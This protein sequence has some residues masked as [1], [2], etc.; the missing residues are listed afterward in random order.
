[1]SVLLLYHTTHY[2]F[3]TLSCLGPVFCERLHQWRQTS[4]KP[5]QINEKKNHQQQQQHRVVQLSKRS[6]S[7]CDT[8]TRREDLTRKGIVCSKGLT[9]G[10]CV[11]SHGAADTQTDVKWFQRWV[12]KRQNRARSAAIKEISPRIDVIWVLVSWHWGCF[13]S[14]SLKTL[15]FVV[16]DKPK[17]CRTGGTSPVISVSVLTIYTSTAVPWGY[18]SP[19]R[20]G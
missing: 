9:L 13:F 16:K 14:F 17:S 10:C 2:A 1:M 20:V 7:F 3:S 18:V 15:I 8:Q 6:Q 4:H 12:T 11:R 5:F 19:S